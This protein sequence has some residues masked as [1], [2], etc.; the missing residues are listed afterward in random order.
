MLP[1]PLSMASD[2]S[3]IFKSPVLWLLSSL[4]FL[5]A[6]L[7]FFIHLRTHST[8]LQPCLCQKCLKHLAPEPPHHHLFFT[9]STVTLSTAA[10][11][12]FNYGEWRFPKVMT[13]GQSHSVL[14]GISLRELFWLLVTPKVPEHLFSSQQVA[15]PPQVRSWVINSLPFCGPSRMQMS[16]RS[17]TPCS[18]PLTPK[19][20]PHSAAPCGRR[21]LDKP[22]CSVSFSKSYLWSFSSNKEHSQ[23]SPVFAKTCSLHYTFPATGPPPPLPSQPHWINQ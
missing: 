22:T 19:G 7:R 13:W 16:L 14:R 1:F 17:C 2:F 8:Y 21:S 15:L 12:L 20:V 4:S 5:L 3:I 11:M 10:G 18:L 6:S 23:V 9:L